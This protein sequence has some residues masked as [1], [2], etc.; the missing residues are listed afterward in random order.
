M[1][2]KQFPMDDLSIKNP[3]TLVSVLMRAPVLIEL[4]GGVNEYNELDLL[5]VLSVAEREINA[6][7]SMY[8]K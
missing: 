2:V 4:C 3:P 6:H 1:N 5:K 7:L 8:V